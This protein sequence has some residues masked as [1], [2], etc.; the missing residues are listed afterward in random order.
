MPR[1]S[2]T[3][4]IVV[5]SMS[6]T[7]VMLVLSLLNTRAA[8]AV[9]AATVPAPA[10]LA[11]DAG[12]DCDYCNCGDLSCYEDCTN[13]CSCN[14]YNN[15][16][17]MHN[18]SNWGGADGPSEVKLGKWCIQDAGDD[19]LQFLYGGESVVRVIDGD[20]FVDNGWVNARG[21]QVNRDQSWAVSNG[22]PHPDL[23]A[24]NSESDN[25]GAGVVAYGGPYMN[26]SDGTMYPPRGPFM[27]SPTSLSTRAA[28][29]TV[30]G[31]SGGSTNVNP[32][33]APTTTYNLPETD[34]NLTAGL[35]VGNWELGNAAS[36]DWYSPSFRV[37]HMGTQQMPLQFP[38]WPGG[39]GMVMGPTTVLH[40]Y[41]MQLRRSEEARKAGSPRVPDI[42]GPQSRADLWSNS[43][44]AKTMPTG[45]VVSGGTG[46][47]TGIYANTNGGIK[48][49]PHFLS[50]LYVTNALTN[51][52]QDGSRSAPTLP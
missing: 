34:P 44:T 11:A 48:H 38:T 50:P 36:N 26:N 28:V 45:I 43:T 22:D 14:S 39:H 31:G 8:A 12:A 46:P 25:T 5:A 32:T 3:A 40:T 17:G 42:W 41:G 19:G 6:I 13:K 29:K 21:L 52:T 4:L 7:V 27:L 33:S 24:S 20:V 10:A 35:R 2:S 23:W 18:P 15:T 49:G 30:S 16:P 51:P 47:G 1:V 37:Q 9:A